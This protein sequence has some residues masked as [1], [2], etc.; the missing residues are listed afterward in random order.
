M[1]KLNLQG[2]ISHK[3]QTSKITDKQK[4]VLMSLLNLD[5]E[6]LEI[7]DYKFLKTGIINIHARPKTTAISILYL[8]N[9]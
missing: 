7:K 8:K 4:S 1:S 9:I 5:L 6:N 3:F 2:T